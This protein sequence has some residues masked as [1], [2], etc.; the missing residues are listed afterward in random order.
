M[1]TSQ[2]T[3]MSYM[4]AWYS[5]TD[6]EVAPTSY[7]TYNFPSMKSKGDNGTGYFTFENVETLEGFFAGHN[8]TTGIVVTGNFN[9][10][11]REGAKHYLQSISGMFKNCTYLQFVDIPEYTGFTT[12]FVED[13]SYLFA[14]CANM[15]ST[16]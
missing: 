8:N 15:K 9:T 13:M 11:R 6:P 4:F 2:V 12:Q 7:E 3:D 5:D 1:D 10:H 16:E 14:N